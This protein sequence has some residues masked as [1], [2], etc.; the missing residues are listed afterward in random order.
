VSAYHDFFGEEHGHESRAT[1]YFQWNE[2]KP[3]H[4]DYCFV[5]RAWSGRIRS[6]T[7]GTYADWARD[8]DHRPLVVDV[9]AGG[10][11]P[12]LLKLKRRTG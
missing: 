10:V 9:A 5:P 4:I 11:S 3:S 6:V 12:G 7:V 2:A 1:H 8:S